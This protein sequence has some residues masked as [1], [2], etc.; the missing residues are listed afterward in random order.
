MSAAIIGVV[1]LILIGLAVGIYFLLNA[2]KCEDHET[3][4]EC[5]E[6]CQWDTYGGK[7]ID[8]EATLTQAPAPAPA[9]TAG[10]NAQTRPQW[11]GCNGIP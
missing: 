10:T 7:C 5:K 2:K 4:D 3:Q 8:E 9:P 1:L 6:P 11:L